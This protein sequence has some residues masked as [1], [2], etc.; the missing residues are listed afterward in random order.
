MIYL[1]IESGGLKLGRLSLRTGW[2]PS[3]WPCHS[4]RTATGPAGC[5]G[6]AD[7][8]DVLARKRSGVA[9][10]A[11]KGARGARPPSVGAPTQ[12]RT[13]RLIQ[14]L[15]PWLPSSVPPARQR[16]CHTSDSHPRRGLSPGKNERGII[17]ARDSRD[18]AVV[19][20]AT[21]VGARSGRARQIPP[22]PSIGGERGGLFEVYSGTGTGED[23]RSDGVASRSAGVREAAARC[24]ARQGWVSHHE[25][26]L[27]P[28]IAQGTTR[29]RAGVS[30]P[31]SLPF[32]DHVQRNRIEAGIAQR[33]PDT[34]PTGTGAV[35]GGRT[36]HE[37]AAAREDP[38]TPTGDS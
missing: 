34:R 16:G 30:V 29:R 38:R 3:L 18:L 36:Q 19:Q 12:G 22:P 23:C 15:C 4:A 11:L 6:G 7:E 9:A 20:Q 2:E 21:G 5:A 14:G 37:H 31:A 17:C 28:L 35:P 1:H 8:G 24:H 27:S 32:L 26:K 25:S 33:A 13:C 10:A